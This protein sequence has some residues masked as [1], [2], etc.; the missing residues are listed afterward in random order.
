MSTTDNELKRQVQ[1]LTAQL[2]E[3]EHQLLLTNQKNEE[4]AADLLLLEELGRYLTSSLALDEVIENVYQ[5]LSVLDV[6]VILLG[7]LDTDNH[8]IQIPL[9]VK[10][11]QKLAP[12]TIS[13]DDRH[14]PAVWCVQN[15]KELLIFEPDDITKYFSAERAG[16]QFDKMMSTIVYEPLIIGDEIVGCLSVQNPTK[17]A[18]SKEQIQLFRALA[19]YSAIAI[20]NA[21]G[22]RKLE[23]TLKALKLTQQQ[24]V[25]QEKMASLGT[26]TAGVAHEINNPTNFIHV[27]CE[28]LAVDLLSFEAFLVELAG[29][30]EADKAVLDSFGKRTAPLHEQLTVIKDGAQRIKTI[31]ED[32]RAF[33]H[34]DDSALKPADIVECLRSTVNLLQIKYIKTAEFVV[35]FKSL[36]E[37]ICYAAKLNQVFMSVIVNGCEAIERKQSEQQTELLGQ[38]TISC[39]AQGEVIII[40]IKDNG[41]GMSDEIKGQLFDPFYTTKDVGKGTGLG[42]S[43]AFGIIK[44][45]GGTIEAVSSELVGSEIMILLPLAP[46][47]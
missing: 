8:Q 30:D 22:Y 33:T 5:S 42:M 35:D 2:A 46:V 19:S 44:E 27:G 13:L 34:L 23:Q 43:V 31:V 38:I 18:Y 3:A 7:I 28:N 24:L 16:A 41:C 14:S 20:A 17:H 32:L 1:Q 15:K 36:P 39:Y 25:L 4:M 47:I 11:H 21:L 6:D 37:L 9:L 29:G 10:G 40:S 26:L 45:H 12:A